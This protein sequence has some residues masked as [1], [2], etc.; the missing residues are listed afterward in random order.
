[1]RGGRCTISA[2][3]GLTVIGG[4]KMG[5]AL[6]GGLIRSEWT[7]PAHIV[8]VEPVEARREELAKAYEGL[9][10]V[11]A[12]TE[13]GDGDVLLAVKPDHCAEVCGA[14]GPLGPRRVLSIAAGITTAALEAAL[15][16]G[17]RVIRAM[18]NTPAL[19]GEAMA[20]VSAGTHADSDD[21]GW[22]TEVLSSVGHVVVLAEE[23]LDAVTG[24]SGSGPAYLFLLAEALTDAGV[25]VGL[26]PETADVLTRQTLLGAA[27][28][29]AR[30]GESPAQLR[31]NVTS[32]NGTT[33]AGIAVFEQA[34]LRSIV[35]DV[36]TA[37]TERSRELGRS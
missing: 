31:A 7:Q 9:R 16:D 1:M 37:A 25:D 22:A 15:P 5:E 11:D 21:L 6:V 32:P 26:D 18:P 3:N 4:G 29:L 14:I 36:V 27:T 28:L 13:L 23:A 10:V 35:R 12:A 20:A 24:V 19:V 30:S 8:V 2:V 34:D 17:T 33:A